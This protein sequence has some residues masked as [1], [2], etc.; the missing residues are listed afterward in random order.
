MMMTGVFRSNYTQSMTEKPLHPLIPLCSLGREKCYIFFFHFDVSRQTPDVHVSLIFPQVNSLCL[1]MYFL[2][3]S[4]FHGYAT[5]TRNKN[6]YHHNHNTLFF[7]VFCSSLGSSSSLYSL[8]L[9]WSSLPLS[10]TV[11][12]CLP[13]SSSVSLPLFSYM[14]T[15]NVRKTTP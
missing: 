2:L 6:Y 5:Y 10:S 1:S 8:N 4:L 15:C 3:D 14:N 9:L 13:L 11:F 12:L 7:L